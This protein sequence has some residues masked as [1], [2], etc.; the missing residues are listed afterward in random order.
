M[1]HRLRRERVG[2]RRR[3]RPVR[4]RGR[5][6]RRPS[7]GAAVPREGRDISG[8]RGL[9]RWMRNWIEA[10]VALA[11]RE[12]QR[13]QVRWPTRPGRA[14][15]PT[16]DPADGR[17]PSAAGIRLCCNSALLH[18]LDRLRLH[19]LGERLGLGDA[20]LRGV[21]AHVLRDL[22]RAEVR[23][24][25]RAEV[26]QLRAVLRQR[27]VVELARLVRIEAEVELVLPAELEARLRQRI[28][29]D[30]RAGWPLAR[31]AAW[32]A[33][34]YAMMPSLTSV[35]FGKAEVLLRRHVAEHRGAV[36]A[37]HR[38]ADRAGDVV[39]A[40]RDVGGERPQRV[41]RR[42]AAQPQLLLHVVLD[43]VH[44]HVA[45]PF[46]HRLHVV[47]P[48]DLRE[49]AQRRELGH[50]RLVV[51]VVARARPQPVAERERDVVRLHDLADVLEMRVEEALAVVREASDSRAQL[52]DVRHAQHPQ[53][54]ADQRSAGQQHRANLAADHD[55]RPASRWRC[56]IC[57]ASR[58]VSMPPTRRSSV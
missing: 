34:L 41:E 46:D 16:E 29:A 54:P 49:L 36:P 6:L 30:L 4:R 32:A 22:H 33:T 12:A 24:A 44:R 51:R 26:R 27:L 21:L 18:E 15:Y 48:R 25:H 17:V 47:L 53:R 13:G 45:G 40:G 23:A 28:V 11:V 56:S 57:T 3:R 58:P 55:P 42:L 38:R 2:G 10:Q 39:V 43:Q 35:L 20:L 14:A 31:S 7:Q 19:P 50:L 9:H 1:P 37:D 8:G 5:A 52:T